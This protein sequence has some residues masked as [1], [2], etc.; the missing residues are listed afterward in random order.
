MSPPAP[1]LLHPCYLS[2]F[3]FFLIILGLDEALSRSSPPPFPHL[4]SIFHFSSLIFQCWPCQSSNALTTSSS[5]L[6]ILNH[7]LSL[8]SL[9][10][11]TLIE[12]Y[13]VRCPILPISA[14][15]PYFFLL[16][17]K[18]GPD[19]M[20]VIEISEFWIFSGVEQSWLLVLG[21]F[22]FRF[23]WLI[24]FGSNFWFGFALIWFGGE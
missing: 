17:L 11:L 18:V 20:L 1:P 14:W 10:V 24:N 23:V 15:S 3:L 22:G 9:S 21:L 12:L 4:R 5:S 13:W 16:S 7:P 8:F 19:G 2:L 6:S